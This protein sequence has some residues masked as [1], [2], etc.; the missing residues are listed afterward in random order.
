M[1]KIRQ[2]THLATGRVSS[3]VT[4]ANDSSASQGD[5]SLRVERHV[6]PE[7]RSAYRVLNQQAEEVEE[8]NDF[9]D[10]IAVRGLSKQTLRTYAYSLLSIASWL[11]KT[12]LLISELTET[13]LAGYVRH[14][15][16]DCKTKAP[17][18]PRSI[19]LRLAVARALYRFHTNFELPT[20]SRSPLSALPVFVPASRVGTRAARRMGRAPLRVKVPR[21]LVVP[22]RPEEVSRLF[23]SFRTFRDRAIGSLMLFCGLRSREVL[24][25]RLLDVNVLQEELRVRGKGDKDRILPLTSHVRRSV[26]TYLQQ[27]RPTTYHE[28]LFVNLKGPTRGSPMTP[29]GLRDLFRYHRKR[30]GVTNAHPHRL[31]HTFAVDMVREGMSLPVLKR[32]MGH[33]NIEM[34]MRYVNLSVEDVR[35]EFERVLRS[36]QKRRS[37]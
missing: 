36:V 10:A 7:G 4:S 1:L 6:A 32:L 8:L 23:E 2:E 20:A 9:L 27:E 12:G 25:L 14:I 17:P 16:E 13:H 37:Q 35:K 11:Q 31:R 18:A 28:T 15:R 3:F 22:L 26:D 19:N 34:T 33:S 29:A 5:R 30:S 24:S 21:C